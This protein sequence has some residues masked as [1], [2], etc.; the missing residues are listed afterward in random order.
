MRVRELHP[1]E[2]AAFRLGRLVAAER[3]PYFMAGLYAATPV[4]AEG[5]GTLAVDRYWRL[6]LDPAL[7][8]G[9]DKW[10]AA[11][12][13]AGLLH[14]VGHLLRDHAGRADDL[15]APV[16]HVAWNYAGDAEINDDL[17]AAGI[18]LPDWCITPAALGLSD[19]DFAENYYAS[20]APSPEDQGDS[21]LP[22]DTDGGCG[23]GS[24]SPALHGELTEE[25]NVSDG[26]APAVDDADAWMVRRVVAE[27][28]ND[29]ASTSRGT[30][31][32]GLQRWAN[33]V[34]APPMIPWQRVLR[35]SVRRAVADRAGR[36]DYT[37]SRPSRR[38]LPRIIK[39]SMRAPSVAVSVVID[40]SG[41]MSE[42]HLTAALSEI[43]GVLRA[44]GVARDK[45]RVMTC[46]AA[47][48][49]AQ[50]VRAVERIRLDGG[51]G[52]DMRVGIA[53]AEH[54][55]PKPHIIVCLT[56][57]FTPWPSE[58]TSARLICAVIGPQTPTNTPAWAT[59]VHI[60]TSGRTP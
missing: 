19:G 42:S 31:P 28:V 38:R 16:H 49:K 29:H 51:G 15:S 11:T 58:P 54:L 41:S 27:A 33:W 22:N 46:D 13:G 32:A 45:F 23:S 24:G 40:T 30:V 53:A 17:L 48:G 43:R 4:A 9:E 1:D 37:Y 21:G 55:T 59:T 18:P 60:S 5:L 56:D 14:E 25:A 6:Y 26:S 20:I 36:T 12:L 35:A 7:L 34:L 44:S 52:T 50:R 2:R 3:C 10:D 8:V 57:G 39:P 47:V